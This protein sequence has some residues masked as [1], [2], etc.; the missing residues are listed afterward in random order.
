[1]QWVETIPARYEVKMIHH[2]GEER[3]LDLTVGRFNYES[4][5]AWLVT[6]FDITERDRAEQ[7]LKRARKDL[8]RRLRDAGQAVD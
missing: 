7:E 6:A 3:W 1:M 2:S 4:A 8:E 5:P